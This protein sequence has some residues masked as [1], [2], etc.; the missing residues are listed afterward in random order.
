MGNPL[1]GLFGKGGHQARNNNINNLLSQFQ[2]FRNNFKGNPEQMV[3]EL[4]RSGKMSDEQFQ[5]LGEIASQ[6]QNV[7]K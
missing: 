6:L 4:R 7:I 2:L 3:Q 1:A 5:Q